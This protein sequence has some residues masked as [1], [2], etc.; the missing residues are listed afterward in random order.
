M[1]Q[2]SCPATIPTKGDPSSMYWSPI[3]ASDLNWNFEKFLIG[4]DGRPF[5]RYHPVN[6]PEDMAEDIRGLISRGQSEKKLEEA[7][8]QNVQ[9]KPRSPLQN[10]LHPKQH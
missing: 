8:A 6:S 10:I 4:Q 5:K 7:M 1:F 2:G 9:H 3:D